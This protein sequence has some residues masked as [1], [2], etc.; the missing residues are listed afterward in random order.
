MKNGFTIFCSALLILV[1]FF[2]AYTLLQEQRCQ[3]QEHEGRIADLEHKNKELREEYQRLME[4][5]LYLEEV[6]REKMGVAREGEIILKIT[7]EE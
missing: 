7:P 2:P 6:A 1:I 3:L 5:P 4:D